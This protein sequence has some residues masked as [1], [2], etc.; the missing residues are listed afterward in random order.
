MGVHRWGASIAL[1]W[2]WGLGLFFSW[3]FA[4][5]YGPVGL[6]IFAIPNALGLLVFG[7]V[8]GHFARNRDLGAWAEDALRRYAWVFFA[9]QLVAIALTLFA[10][11]KY[12]LA[13]LGVSAPL[14]AGMALLFLAFVAV[15]R[16]SLEG[17]ARFHAIVLAG[18]AFSF[19]VM[20]A[21]WPAVPAGVAE[22]APR[23]MSFLALC[24]PIALGLLLGPW[25]DLQQW[26]RAVHL[27]RQ[28]RSVAKAFAVGSGLFLLLLLAN[29][30]LAIWSGVGSTAASVGIFDQ[31]L[32]AEAAFPKFVAGN[33]SILFQSAFLAWATGAVFTTFDSSHLAMRWFNDCTIA[34]SE[35][36]LVAL[37]P[38]R[39]RDVTIP[40][41]GLCALAAGLGVALG[42]DLE[43]F[44]IFYAS[45]F[46]AY[47][48]ALFRETMTGELF[49]SRSQISSLGIAS[50]CLLAAGY[51]ADLPI[52]VAA[53]PVVAVSSYWLVGRAN[54]NANVSAAAAAKA[55]RSDLPNKLQSNGSLP[56]QPTATKA[57]QAS[58]VF[59]VDN[60]Q[61]GQQVASQGWF[62]D[63]KWFNIHVV[64]TYGDTNSVGNV[65]FSS[66][67]NWI[68]KTRE[69]F[70]RACMPDFDLK[71]TP[72]YI[73]TR[74]FQHKFA[75]ETRE[76]EDLFCR[77]KIK[78]YNRKFVELH[79]EIRDRASKLVGEGSQTLMFVDSSDY[80]LIDIPDPVMTAFLP[81]APAV[82]GVS[83]P[84][85][86]D[87]A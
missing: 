42:I 77:L 84:P 63:E 73:L 24:V 62:D 78:S 54:A 20:L 60:D 46:L 71:I 26:Q 35:S 25:F 21:S 11:A 59:G 67:V 69:L 16:M 10:F 53:A 9:Y 41:F 83:R 68:G 33:G 45:L 37:L 15:E 3:H 66:Y 72:F 75:R 51:L 31:Y 40:F 1:S 57:A 13:P 36:F 29:G 22:T 70:F 43:Y 44:M 74:T 39:V 81:L 38:E 7:L 30:C 28:G 58:A 61:L 52:F 6:L 18:L 47:S 5:L 17:L 76:F 8:T 79:H 50:L 86:R 55:G 87:I 12:L 48:A 32:H 56:A 23:N 34:K 64:S 19:V 85:V 27:A 2:L 65:Y 82:G 80:R 49:P 14:L 4:A